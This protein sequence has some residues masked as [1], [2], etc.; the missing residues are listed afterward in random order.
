[1]ILAG[2]TD[3]FATLRRYLVDYGYLSRT[4]DGSVYHKN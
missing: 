1:V 3:D 4:S 2:I